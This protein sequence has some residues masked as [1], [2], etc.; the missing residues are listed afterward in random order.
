MKIWFDHQ[1]FVSQ[2]YGGVSRYFFELANSLN[3]LA[4]T[5][6]TIFAPFHINSYLNNS[7]NLHP[8]SFQFA[9]PYR[10]QRFRPDLIAPLFNFFSRMG[11]PDIVHET[12]YGERVLSR[13]DGSPAIVTTIHDMIYEK[14]PLLFMHAQERAEHKLLAMKQADRII[15]ISAH[16]RRDLLDLYPY[17]ADKVE[18][19]HHGVS[20][21]QADPT[22]C[23]GFPEPYLLFVGVRTGYKNFTNFIKA[24]GSSSFLSNTFSVLCFGGGALTNDELAL[25]EKSGF[26][27]KRLHQVSGPDVLLSQAYRQATALVFPSCYE[28]FGMPLTEA[29]VQSCPILCA[30]AS[31]FPEICMNAAAYFDPNNVDSIK[32]CL[33]KTLG[34]PI[35]LGRLSKAAKL[36]SHNFSWD[37]CAQETAK[38]YEAAL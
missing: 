4:Q 37:K 33:E 17:L 25:A 10:G 1:I 20:H 16:T 36:R 3:K 5:D 28:G 34:D 31:C 30:D 35:E 12:Y 13:K 29:M 14:Y 8:I 32:A 22:N 18:V 11:K 19:I 24:I 15:C 26:P 9:F 6:A 2:Q 23:H 21:K 27:T 7:G 38:A